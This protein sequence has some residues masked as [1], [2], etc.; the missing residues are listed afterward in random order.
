MW[1]LLVFFAFVS[2]TLHSHAGHAVQDFGNITSSPEALAS[3]TYFYVGG[4]YVAVRNPPSLLG[5]L[6]I[7]LFVG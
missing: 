5:L 6:R 7:C 4:G 1:P 2:G 3:R